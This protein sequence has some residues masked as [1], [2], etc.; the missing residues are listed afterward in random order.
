MRAS[1]ARAE[2][3]TLRVVPFVVPRA[4]NAHNGARAATG[5]IG[6]QSAANGI[7]NKFMGSK[8]LAICGNTFV[9]T[10]RQPIYGI[11]MWAAAAWMAFFGPTLSSFT[12]ESGGDTKMLVDTCLATMLLFGLLASVFSATGVITREIE[13]FTVLTVISKPVSRPVFFVGKF[14]GVAG[15][16][17][18]AYYFLAIVF[19]M[20]VRH[21]VMETSADKYDMPVVVLG[22]AALIVS[23]VAAAFCNFTYGWHFSTTLTAWVVPLATVALIITLFFDKEW[24]PQSPNT[25][26]GYKDSISP[27]SIYF[28]ITLTFLAVMMLTAFAVALSARFSQTVTLTLCSGIFVLGLLS[29]HYF[30]GANAQETLLGQVAYRALPNFQF[31]WLGDAIT[32]QLQV[33]PAHFFR[34]AAYAGLYTLGILGL[35]TAL[36]QT[37]EVG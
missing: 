20:T 29:D 5:D 6:G 10:I 7:R 3:R 34:V 8:F 26:F 27:Q 9:E 4:N 18:I 25:Y 19:V 11:L 28:A 33:K 13:S 21:G 17:L 31:F 24:K 22:G 36:F 30:G 2:P 23:L 35:G 12:L 32:Q 15:A 14:A 1:A 37:R 16:M